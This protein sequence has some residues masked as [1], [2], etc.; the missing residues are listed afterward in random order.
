MQLTC[1][2]IGIKKRDREKT[3]NIGI[4]RNYIKFRTEQ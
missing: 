3:T 4:N 1:I 2:D